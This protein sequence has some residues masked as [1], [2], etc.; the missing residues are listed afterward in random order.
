MEI[1][2][3]WKGI[4]FINSNNLLIEE[5]R[6]DQIYD[7]RYS[8]KIKTDTIFLIMKSS[9]YRII[10]V[11]EKNLILEYKNDIFYLM[12]YAN[13]ELPHAGAELHSMPTHE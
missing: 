6:D 9:N 4:F 8:I 2:S 11:T 3:L 10:E 7:G 5:E 12:P 13:N 1:Q